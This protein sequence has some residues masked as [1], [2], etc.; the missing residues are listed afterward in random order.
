[1][2]SFYLT[3]FP[4]VD[5]PA[6]TAKSRYRGGKVSA[7]KDKDGDWIETGRLAGHQWIFRGPTVGSRALYI[8]LSV[9][10]NMMDMCKMVFKLVMVAQPIRY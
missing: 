2:A 4:P 1:M 9:A 3:Q 7:W 6:S 8:C 10:C 5:H